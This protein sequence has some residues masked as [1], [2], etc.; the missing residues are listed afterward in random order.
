MV[1]WGLVRWQEANQANESCGRQIAGIGITLKLLR[2]ILDPV[3]LRT[4]AASWSA[5]PCDSIPFGEPYFP[6]D[7]T[8]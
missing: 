3:L 6:L 4:S 7:L 5:P 8:H 2:L 1:F